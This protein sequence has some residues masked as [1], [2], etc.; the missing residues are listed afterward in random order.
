[1]PK[2]R[3]FRPVDLAADSPPDLNAF[4]PV[5]LA[6]GDSWFSLG[7]IPAHNLLDQLSFNTH[8][9][10]VNLAHP[11]D[12]AQ[13][14]RRQVERGLM[15]RMAAWGSEFASFVSDRAAYP[16]SAI[17]LSAGGNDLIDAVPHLLK[18][19]F[20]FRAVDPLQPAGALD[21]DQLAAFDGYV[22]DSLRGLVGFVREHGGINRDAPVFIH[23]YDFP[24]P[25]N[26]PATVF[27]M[28]VG[29][30]WLHPV[31][32]RAGLP[33]ELWQPLT[34]HL[35]QHLAAVIKSLDLPDYH[36]VHTLGTIERARPDA[37]GESGDWENEIHPNVTGYRKLA[38]RVVAAVREELG[39]P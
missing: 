31:L 4:T 34:D 14:M 37:T 6:E 25:N 39:L 26:A 27:G 22:A 7:S 5:L 28:R 11:G 18:K 38:A 15:R 19:G 12:T 2:A 3:V 17:L 23:T 35:L 8:G 36:V 30:A 24:T 20:D 16:Y 33:T 21:P 29:S 32:T 9:A 10:V 1:M 13:N